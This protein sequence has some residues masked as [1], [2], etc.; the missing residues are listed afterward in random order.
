MDI[1]L[2]PKE[3]L[4]EWGNLQIYFLFKVTD[5]KVILSCPTEQ[6][7]CWTM[8]GQGATCQV[9]WKSGQTAAKWLLSEG[10]F[11]DEQPGG[12]QGVYSVCSRSS[13]GLLRYT[14]SHSEKLAE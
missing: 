10:R 12:D 9:P 13:E 7:N 6:Q 14:Y 5:H 4:W 11:Y 1:V 8:G 2:L 3:K